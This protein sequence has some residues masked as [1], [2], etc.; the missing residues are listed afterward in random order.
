VVVD[1]CEE[2]AAAVALRDRLTGGIL[3]C[4]RPLAGGGFDP[5]VL[6][7]ARRLGARLTRSKI[8]S[9][10]SNSTCASGGGAKPALEPI[11]QPEAELRLGM[12]QQLGRGG[13]DRPSSFA[14]S[15]TVPSRM[16]ARNASICRR[17]TSLSPLPYRKSLW[18]SDIS[19]LSHLSRGG[20]IRN[21]TQRSGEQL[22]SG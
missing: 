19:V 18:L 15:V 20:L 9:T 3:L 22:R 11:E 16:I 14:A 7:V 8:T 17:F 2:D 1:R 4:G 5:S 10:S 21:S 12:L 13:L 6:D